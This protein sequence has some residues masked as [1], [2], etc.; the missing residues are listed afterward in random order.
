[1][2]VRF[3]LLA[4]A[5]LA[6]TGYPLSAAEPRQKEVTSTT[7]V[8]E[9]KDPWRYL[10]YLPDGYAKASEQSWPLLVYLHGRSAR[11]QDFKLVKRY[12]PPNF[13]ERRGDFPF[14]VISPQLPDDSWPAQSVLKLIDEVASK[15][16]IDKSCICLT[17]VSLGGG[18]AWYVAAADPG[19]FA[20]FAPVCGY[21]DPGVAKKV[22]DLPIW[23]F[24]GSKDEILPVETHQKLVN[25]VN[26]A[27]GNAKITVLPDEDH[28]SVISPAYKTAGLWDWMLSQSAA[29]KKSGRLAGSK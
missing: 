28:G 23:A 13:L 18:G 6:S 19:R 29:G 14:V 7:P 27:G 5:L 11:G 3:L 15:Y 8:A 20:A 16:R 17:G 21:G 4:A 25:A 24:H 2:P 9:G 26:A 22:K 12:G 1:M 10:L